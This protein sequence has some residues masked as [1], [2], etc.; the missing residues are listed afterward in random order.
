MATRR[1]RQLAQHLHV[2]GSAGGRTGSADDSLRLIS[3]DEIQR[4]QMI[5]DAW[6]VING[7]VYDITDFIKEESG[8]PGGADIPMEYAGKDATE[9]WTDMQCEAQKAVTLRRTRDNHASPLHLLFASNCLHS[10]LSHFLR[11]LARSGHIQE[12]ILAAIDSRDPGELSDLGLE[13]LPVVIGLADGEAPAAAKGA[14][15][16]STNWAGNILWSA[17]EVALPE[18]VGEL[19]SLVVAAAGRVRCVGRSHSFTPAA[20]TGWSASFHG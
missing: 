12:E 8:H 16:P 4:H 7:I 2:H 3:W 6:V 14:G 15:F 13:A 17:S 11:L 18:S 1:V 10:P 9:F 20:D 5:E 19:Q